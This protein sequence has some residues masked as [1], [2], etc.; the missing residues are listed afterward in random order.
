M[1]LKPLPQWKNHW[2]ESVGWHPPRTDNLLNLPCWTLYRLW[3]RRSGKPVCLLE[4]IELQQIAEDDF[5]WMRR[6]YRL[7]PSGADLQRGRCSSLLQAVEE[8]E[9][10]L[11]FHSA[12]AAM[13]CGVSD[14][15]RWAGL[16]ASE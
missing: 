2:R 14:S 5:A 7:S 11:D 13:E 3:V 8:A 12:H 6:F 10:V 9:A 15:R 1:A 4:T 16:P